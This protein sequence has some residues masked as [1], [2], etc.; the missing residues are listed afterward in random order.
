MKRNGSLHTRLATL[1]GAILLAFAGCRTDSGA[2]K[3]AT[4]SLSLDSVLP[5]SVGHLVFLYKSVHSTG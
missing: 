4:G 3:G 1:C 2:P 5:S